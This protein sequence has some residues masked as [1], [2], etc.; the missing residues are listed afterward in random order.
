[1]AN[2][3]DGKAWAAEWH[4]TYDAERK[5]TWERHIAHQGQDWGPDG[6]WAFLREQDVR[7]AL[8]EADPDIAKVL[9]RDPLAVESSYTPAE[10]GRKWTQPDWAAVVVGTESGIGD[11]FAHKD[12]YRAFQRA[13]EILNKNPWYWEF[14]W[15]WDSINPAV[16]V[17]RMRPKFD[18]LD[19]VHPKRTKNPCACGAKHNPGVR[20]EDTEAAIDK[21]N[22]FHRYD[23]RE[24]VEI[25]LVIPRRVRELGAAKHVLYRSAKVD[26]D[27][28]KKP[29]RP[30]DYIHEHDPG[31]TAYACDG[32]ADCDVP[33]EFTEVGAVV[34]LGKCLGFALEDGTEAEGTDPLPDLCCTPDGRCLLVVQGKKRVL[35]MMWGGDLGVFARGID[36]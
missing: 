35:A 27:T 12:V 1:M 16:H 20:H 18:V 26:P 2:T 15:G 13:V 34:V 7:A 21:Y 19:V 6:H 31:V 24:V 14:T 3:D 9:E 32:R 8:A 36:G 25:D 4:R 5:A 11:P 22:E 10:R 17:F 29:K 30:V 23:P 33:D 28:L